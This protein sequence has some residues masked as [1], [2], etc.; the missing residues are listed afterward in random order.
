MVKFQ[1][2]V[3]IVALSASLSAC[4]TPTPPVEVIRFHADDI[5]QIKNVRPDHRMHFITILAKDEADQDS[6]EHRTYAAAVWRE[7]QRIGFDE[8]ID[9]ERTQP[10]YRTYQ[11]VAKIGV[12]Q[13][14][15]TANG[16]RSPV[17][18]GVGGRTGGYGS[19]VGVGIDIN[20]GGA[21]K[22]RIVTELSVQILDQTD[23]KVV[24]EGRSTVDAKDGSPASQPA[25][26]ASKLAEALF[27]DFPGE[28]GATIKVP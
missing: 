17:S 3:F 15:V 18:V 10:R 5:G 12:E 25:L 20:L 6:L 21:P 27:T 2:L 26:A 14:K 19:G 22:D 4:V 24:W 11:Y 9:P 13:S 7:L 16:R 23:N 1:R 8:T 28:S